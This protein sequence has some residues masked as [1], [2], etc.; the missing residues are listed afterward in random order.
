M[1]RLSNLALGL[2]LLGVVGCGQDHRVTSMK[3][4]DGSTWI[5]LD[6]GK[7]GVP[8]HGSDDT[9]SLVNQ[10]LQAGCKIVKEAP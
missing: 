3:I 6:C 7:D 2:G 10:L 9:I 4:F 5:V 8:L 1:A